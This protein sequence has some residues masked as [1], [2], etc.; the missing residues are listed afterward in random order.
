MPKCLSSHS[1]LILFLLLMCHLLLRL[2]VLLHW[3]HRWASGRGPAGLPAPPERA[4]PPEPHVPLPP[5]GGVGRPQRQEQLQQGPAPQRCQRGGPEL[6]DQPLHQ[7][8]GWWLL[9]EFSTQKSGLTCSRAHITIPVKPHA[10]LDNK[11]SFYLYSLAE[12]WS[13]A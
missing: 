8:L 9:C 12:L 13:M 3:L 6:R 7:S 4:G 2:P 5:L 10:A 11:C 1:N